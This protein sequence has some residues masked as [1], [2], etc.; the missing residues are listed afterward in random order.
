MWHDEKFTKDIYDKRKI[1]NVDESFFKAIDTEEKAYWL[2]FIAADG[3][4]NFYK[5]S[6]VLQDGDRGAP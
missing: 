3:N 6:I 4:V 2:G 1:L 5:L